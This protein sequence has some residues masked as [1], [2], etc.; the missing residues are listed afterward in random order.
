MTSALYLGLMSGTSQDGVDAALVEFSGLRFSRIVSTHSVPYSAPLRR[1]LLTLARDLPPLTLR[2]FCTLDRAVA[3]TFSRAALAA[4]KRKRISSRHVTAIGSHGQ[5][6]F[7]APGLSSLQL[8]DPNRIAALTGIT[9][10][11]DF[12][13]KDVALGGQGAPLLPAFHHAMFADRRERRCV[14]NIG[15]IAQITALPDTRPG[16]ILG[17][18][19]GP[20]NGLLDEWI[21][22]QRGLD[23]DTSGRWAASGECDDR[24]LT[25]LLRDPYFQR[26]T[27]KST[28]RDYFNLAWVRRRYP[29]LDRLPPPSVQNTMTEL[30]AVSIAH[31]IE[32]AAPRTSR[33]LVCGGGVRNRYLMQ[34]LRLHLA[35]RRVETTNAY[36]IEA[37]WVEATAFAWLAMR[38][39][40]GLPGNLPAVTG[41]KRAVI[42][43][44]IYKS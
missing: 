3:D 17:F 25:A 23:Y 15:G 4:L 11:A 44:G 38:T 31:A 24:M 8:G 41:A 30:T 16:S 27:P 12:R 42:L 32:R 9:T 37:Q 21:K 40:R 39:M 18:D 14:V 13:R 2:D 36:G 35:P 7:H 5:T 22:E 1:Q 34:R 26:R 19:T 33:V 6:V 20:G 43:G 29:N 28:G 10:V